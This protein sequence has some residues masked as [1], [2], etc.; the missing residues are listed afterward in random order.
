MAVKPW[1]VILLLLGIFIAGG[2]TG[3]FVMLRIGRELVARRAMPEQW[4]PQQLKRLT[5]RLDLKP[6]QVEQLR[7]IVRRNM[8]E[9]GRLRNYSVREARGIFERM[10]R[11]I[12]EQL[13][14]DQRIKFEQMNTEM[15]ERARRFLPDRPNR[16]FG[17]GG[18]RSER[19]RPM[20]EP[21]KPAD[22]PPPPPD[23]PAG[24]N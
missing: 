24:G 6:E 8:E 17:P 21:G 13:T 3:A 1:K 20:G 16:L 10:E 9:M 23:K 2:V 4:A 5:E 15:R 22:E 12:S 14:P 18:L 19:E 7:P 11:E